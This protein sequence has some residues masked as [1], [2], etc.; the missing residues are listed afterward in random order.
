MESP[1]RALANILV[2][3]MLIGLVYL[4]GYLKRS[5]SNAESE[6]EELEER[7]Y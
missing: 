4:L 2:P 1:L 5:R 6:T 7:G 3:A